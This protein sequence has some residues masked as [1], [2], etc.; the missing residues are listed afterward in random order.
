MCKIFIP[1][2][3]FAL[4]QGLRSAD[5]SALLARVCTEP[6]FSRFYSLLPRDWVLEKIVIVIVIVIVQV[7]VNYDGSTNS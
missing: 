6:L 3:L 1:L 2:A 5:L 4:A 7:Q